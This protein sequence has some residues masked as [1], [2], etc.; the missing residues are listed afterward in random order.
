MQRRYALS[1]RARERRLRC[2]TEPQEPVIIDLHEPRAH[3]SLCGI[4]GRLKKPAHEA[5]LGDGS[6]RWDRRHTLPREL[7]GHDRGA[8]R[9]SFRREQ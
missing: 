4:V 8:D 2:E 1:C 7:Y 6:G 9:C 3:A 5:R